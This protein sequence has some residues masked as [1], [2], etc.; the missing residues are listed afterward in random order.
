MTEETDRTIESHYDDHRQMA[1][2]VARGEHRVAIGGLWQEL[3]A[4]Q[5][6]FLK[7]RGLRTTDRLLDLGCGS[8]RGGVHYVGY[9]NPGRY[10]GLDLSQALL[11][12]GYNIELA[13]AGLQDRC[14][15]ENLLADDNFRAERFGV[16]FDKAI[17]VSV[18]THMSLN[19]IRQALEKLAPVMRPGGVFYAT[20]F[21][22]PE[23]RL[24]GDPLV[25]GE[26][27]TYP[28][29]DP[30]HYRPSDLEHAAKGLPFRVRRIGDWG[31][32]RGQF[33]T[34]FER[35]AEANDPRDADVAAAANLKAGADHYRA[36]VGPPERFDFMSAT[37]FALLFQAGLK[38]T[39]KVLDLG[40]GSL[41]LGRLLIPFLSRGGYCGIEPNRW[42]IDDGI[43]KELGRDAA[44]LKAPRFLHNEDF[45]ASGFAERFHFVIAQSIATHTGP[46]MLEAMIKGAA[47]AVWKDGL[48]LFSYIR[49]DEAKTLPGEGWFYPGCVPYT[50]SYMIERLGAAGLHARPLA[51]HHPAASWMAASPDPARLPTEEEAARL[52][53]F[54]MPRQR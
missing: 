45:D 33:M 46:A 7:A 50:A 13:Q 9:L 38:E 26:I 4:L 53:G 3:G 11:D 42:L 37:Q 48:F 17:A 36:F 20:T 49:D 41:R 23:D 21:E 52:D 51:W 29:R 8:L 2:R 54:V 47:N 12:A 32:P 1:A 27:T 44:D 28:D 6:S 15:K 24:T 10:Y 5:L 31:H 39:D 25:H 16:E 30:Y 22:C 34:A 19:K 40:C 43:E 18:F 14:P 35:L